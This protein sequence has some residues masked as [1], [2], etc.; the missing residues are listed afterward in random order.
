MPWNAKDYQCRDVFV[1]TPSTILDAPEKWGFSDFFT[2]IDEFLEIS[3]D[4]SPELVSILEKTKNIDR[5]L[6]VKELVKEMKKIHN[7]F[8]SLGM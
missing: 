5:T 7:A 3:E 4:L 8:L 2:V 6:P 1:N